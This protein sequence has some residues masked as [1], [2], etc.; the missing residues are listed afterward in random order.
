LDAVQRILVVNSLLGLGLLALA[1]F[2]LWLLRGSALFRR[3]RSTVAFSAALGAAVGMAFAV[4]AGYLAPSADVPILIGL[5]A[6][7]MVIVMAAALFA[8]LA[9]LFS[10]ALLGYRR[11]RSG[12]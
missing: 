11:A 7:A 8:L 12:G 10:S 2:W 3:V 9:L 4:A 5:W 1:L 6:M